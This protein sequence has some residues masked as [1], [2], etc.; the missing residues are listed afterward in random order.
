VSKQVLAAG[1]REALLLVYFTWQFPS[2]PRFPEYRTLLVTELALELVRV[3]KAR[4][5]AWVDESLWEK[6][7]DKPLMVD[8]LAV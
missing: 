4:P 5:A 8:A 2:D 6:L 7:T 1:V 3:I